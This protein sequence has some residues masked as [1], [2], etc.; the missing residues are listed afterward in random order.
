M[1][2]LQQLRG[3]PLT[4]ALCHQRQVARELRDSLCQLLWAAAQ[5][6]IRLPWGSAQLADFVEDGSVSQVAFI[7]LDEAMPGDDVFKPIDCDA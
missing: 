2:P 4:E 5:R 1:Q 7:D 6:G 3:A